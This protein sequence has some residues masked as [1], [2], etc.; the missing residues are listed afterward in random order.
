MNDDFLH[1][2][3]KAPRAEFTA[4]L[5]K[6]ISKPVK[7]RSQT[8][9][10]RFMALACT[11]IMLIGVAFF[12]SPTVRALA[13]SIIRQ[14]GAFTFIQAPPEPKPIQNIASGQ[15]SAASQ[16]K[17]DPIGDQADQLKKQSQANE[18]VT[19]SY[20]QDAATASQLTGF[21]VL[22]PAYLPDGYTSKIENALGGWE[23]LHE[24]GEVRASSSFENQ[25]VSGFLTIEQFQH[26]PG[27]TKTV[28]SQ[29]ITDVTVHGQSGVWIP[30]HQKHLLVWEEN[31]I[32]YLVISNQ[33]SLEEVL[34][35]AESLGK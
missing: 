31:G 3:R 13:D 34:N 15:Q 7:T 32:T 19:A 5:Y 33:L 27:Q 29:E 30:D 21:S 16:E 35:V 1:Q 26:L 24:N 17:K 6:R 4:G 2:F 25:D 18:N 11:L 20:A 8:Q 10:I 23:I 9:S 28:E 22:A 12:F 14:F